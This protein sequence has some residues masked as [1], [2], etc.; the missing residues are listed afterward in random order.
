MFLAKYNGEGN[1]IWVRQ[2]NRLNNDWGKDMTVD[3]AGDIL[4]LGESYETN[5]LFEMF[6]AKFAGDGSILWE[7][8]SPIVGLGIKTDLSS[9]VFVLARFEG[10]VNF[11]D[12][13]LTAAGGN[14]IVILKYSQAGNLL[15]LQQIGGIRD[16]G[17]RGDLETDVPGNVFIVGSFE[18]SVRFGDTSLMSNG[19]SDIVAA[20]LDNDL[21]L[22]WALPAGGTGHDQAIALALGES[23][24]IFMTGYFEET[25]GF[26]NTT[27]E[28]FGRDDA[29]VAKIVTESSAVFTKN[30]ALPQAPQLFQ[31]FPNPFNP[32]TV[33]SY[34]LPRVSD[35]AVSIYDLRGQQIATW[36]H[37]KQSAGTH[38]VELN[39]QDYLGRTLSSGVYVY[40]LKA[41]EHMQIRK[42]VFLK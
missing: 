34:Y 19:F 33:I 6:I 20:K 36:V 3:S 22:Y 32:M 28:S 25:A 1:L 16:D 15:S 9:H 17:D 5:A 23:G 12:T 42:M 21:N 10:V 35:V 39:A 2:H 8:K 18:E 40:C 31:N 13:T 30:F 26:G 29:F 27:L 38:Q 7:Q 4:I 37:K 24:D 11:G 14:D 41:E